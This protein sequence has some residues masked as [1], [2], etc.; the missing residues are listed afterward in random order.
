MD[1]KIKELCEKRKISI[2]E[3]ARKCGLDYTHIMAMVWG[4]KELYKASLDTIIRL[5]SVLK[6]KPYELLENEEL[7]N[8]IKRWRI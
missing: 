6:C 5:C 8:K 3:L 2:K 1:N 7:A 4:K